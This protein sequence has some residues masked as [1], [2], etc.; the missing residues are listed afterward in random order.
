MDESKKYTMTHDAF[1]KRSMSQKNVAIEFFSANLPEDILKLIDLSS[2][3]QEKS[4]F[5][6]NAIGQGIVDMVY[7]VKCDNEIGY[8]TLL[9][10]HQSTPTISWPS[11]YRNTC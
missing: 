11:V 3:K 4:D 8:I 6:D 7:S 9:L 5:V 1:I 10:K 2:L